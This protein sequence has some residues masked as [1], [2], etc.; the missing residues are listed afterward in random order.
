MPKQEVEPAPVAGV[1]VFVDE[2]AQS[3]IISEC[4]HA[5]AGG[6]INEAQINSLGA[7]INGSHADRT[8]HEQMIR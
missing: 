4:R 2:V 6:L 8:L 3:I 7:V 5:I 1:I